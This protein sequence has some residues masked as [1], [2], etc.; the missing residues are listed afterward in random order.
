MWLTGGSI[1]VSSTEGAVSPDYRVF[2]ADKTL[3]DARYLHHLLRSAPYRDQYNLFVRA[4]TTF[5]RRI[6]QI[7]L[8]Q[9]PLWLPEVDE[10][11]RIA[12]FLDDRVARI[13][14]IITARQR[15]LELIGELTR[16]SFSETINAASDG[17]IQVKRLLDS[18]PD[19][20]LLPDETSSDRTLPRYIRTT[21]IDDQ[22]RLRSDTFLSVDRSW[23][24]GYKVSLGD[25]LI[26]RSGTIGRAMVVSEDIEAVFAGY[27]VRLRFAAID[28]WSYWFVTKTRGFA[29][30]LALNA[31]Q[32]TILNFNADR[33]ASMWI[34]D[35]RGRETVMLPELLRRQAETATQEEALTRT[36]ALLEEYKRSLITAAVTGEL[37]VT[38][39]G[40]GV[41]G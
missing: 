7:D 32:S 15:Q 20:G 24:S 11:R 19:Y 1:A 25:V 18:P 35:F 21:D 14:Q 2:A 22:G 30:Q 6:Q 8:D 33:Y 27:L 39:A 16:E 40:S 37:D 17:V 12:D 13:D 10:Q 41:P 28:P 5:D 36:L 38:T 34:P 9:M 4:N 3:L 26:A 29:D 31:V 23:L